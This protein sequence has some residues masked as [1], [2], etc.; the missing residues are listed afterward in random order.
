MK[1]FENV[2]GN[3]FRLLT[4]SILS[5]SNNV[6]EGL[7]K[8]FSSAGSEI[9]YSR[10]QNVGLGYIKDI[11]EARKCA[12][13]EAKEL[14]LEF[15]YSNNEE[16]Q[17]FVKENDFSKL[18]AE[19]PEHRMAQKSSG[20]D[21][22]EHDMSNPEESREVQI[23]KEILHIITELERTVGLKEETHKIVGLAQ[24]LIQ[25]HQGQ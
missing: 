10:L 9:P 11:T 13:Q 20:E 22:P 24:E 5:E 4:E 25:M 15:G 18:S 2:S 21:H 7:K 23:A 16:E 1:L 8:V 12:L 19:N 6:R 3:Q 17:K 14:A